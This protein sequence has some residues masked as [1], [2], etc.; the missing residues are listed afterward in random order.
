[1]STRRY[2]IVTG[3]PMGSKTRNNQAAIDTQGGAMD[4]GLALKRYRFGSH[5]RGPG[6]G[7]VWHVGAGLAR[8][9]LV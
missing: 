8:Q 3:Q 6:D 4:A 9:Y 1:M 5:E 7:I 2:P